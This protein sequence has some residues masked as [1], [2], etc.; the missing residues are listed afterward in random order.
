MENV[1]VRDIEMAEGHCHR[2]KTS[3]GDIIA[4]KVIVT[5]NAL[6]PELLPE[7]AKIVKPVTNTVLAS[8]PIP[9]HLLP[10]ISGVSERKR[11]RGGLHE[12]QKRSEAHSR[13]ASG[14]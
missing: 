5:T 1:H 12:Y 9:D 10:K 11:K 8:K 14:A 3:R 13:S 4:K 6:I 2:L 7:L